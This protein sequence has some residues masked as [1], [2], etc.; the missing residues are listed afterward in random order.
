ML[1]QIIFDYAGSEEVLA[2]SSLI[3]IHQ[4][5]EVVNLTIYVR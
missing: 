2:F 3:K 4:Y 5:K 1:L